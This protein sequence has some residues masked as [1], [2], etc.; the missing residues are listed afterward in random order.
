MSIL[1]ARAVM[2]P[3]TSTVTNLYLDGT[4]S[5]PIA[6]PS[7]TSWV[8]RAEVVGR[9][10]DAGT[11]DEESGAYTITGLIER[12][13]AAADTRIVG[14]VTTTVI[15]EDDAAWDATATADTTNGALTI[16]V[17]GNNET[18]IRWVATVYL[19]QVGG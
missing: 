10:T 2:T 16:T 4:S 12:D 9:T 13:N 18:T 7:N 14:S 1:T 15:A 11:G 6:L 8:F 5:N 19:T 3:A 17:T